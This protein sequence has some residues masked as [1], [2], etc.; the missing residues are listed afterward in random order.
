MGSIGPEFARAGD[1]L[2]FVTRSPLFGLLNH[3]SNTIRPDDLRLPNVYVE[4]TDRTLADPQ[5]FDDIG[6]SLHRPGIIWRRPW[7]RNDVDVFQLITWSLGSALIITE[8]RSAVKH[9]WLVATFFWGLKPGVS[10]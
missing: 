6:A 1:G 9:F 5:W 3:E 2:A 7:R 8:R 4:V 10:I